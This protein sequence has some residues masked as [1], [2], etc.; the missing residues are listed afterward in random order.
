MNILIIGSDYFSLATDP[1]YRT[2]V[3][4]Q[5]D[6]LR[7]PPPTLSSLLHRHCPEFSPDIVLY[8]DESKLPTLTGLEDLEIPL[9]GYLIDSHIHY[10]WH[11]EFAGMFDHVFV[12]QRDCCDSIN[13]HTGNCGW[14]PLFAAPEPAVA[15]EVIHDVSFVGTLDRGLNPDRVSFIES[16]ARLVPLNVHSGAFSRI[17]RQ[18][19]IVLNQSV[20]TDI[21]FRVFEALASGS[22]LLTDNV[23]NGMNDLLEEGKHFVSYRKND[24][25]DAARKI[26][27]FLEH[28]EERQTIARAGHEAM[29]TRHTKDIRRRQLM[30]G[31]TSLISEWG[32]KNPGISR[33]QRRNAAART[34]LIVA[35]LATDLR[36]ECGIQ[37]PGRDG[38]VDLAEICLQRI[39]DHG[40]IEFVVRDLAWISILRNRRDAAKA[41]LSAAMRMGAADVETFICAADLA[42]DQREAKEHLATAMNL[43]QG[44]SESDPLYYESCFDQLLLLAKRTGAI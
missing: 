24:P 15:E 39:K 13:R 18:S 34:Y 22:L 11:R 40:N 8:T 41:A 1:A 30:N 6:V 36:R 7:P 25:E 35:R 14:L 42:S 20:K 5:P 23:D 29:V 16:L 28:E 4:G 17:F 44:Y 3:L 43:L 19:R 32:G 9:F 10:G 27:Y 38:Y 33:E 12:A 21:N 2:V 31:I 26:R 37:I